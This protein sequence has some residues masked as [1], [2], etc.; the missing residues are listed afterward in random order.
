[1]KTARFIP[2]IHSLYLLAAGLWPV[3]HLRSFIIVTGDKTD[4]WLVHSVGLLSVAL[5]I[6]FLFAFIKR[7]ITEAMFVL[8]ISTAL[9][10]AVIDFYYAFTG[11]IS[12][13]YVFDGVIQVLFICLYLFFGRKVNPA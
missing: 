3:L 11:V 2:F 13:V 4:V 8:A 6:T 7:Q 5:G 1:M 12:P 10:F 9:G